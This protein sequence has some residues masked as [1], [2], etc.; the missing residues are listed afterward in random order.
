MEA[1]SQH[2]NVIIAL[3]GALENSDFRSEQ[4]RTEFCQHLAKGMNEAMRQKLLTWRSN[5]L[6]PQTT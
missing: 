5:R 4:E 1:P 6:A 3:Q 2:G